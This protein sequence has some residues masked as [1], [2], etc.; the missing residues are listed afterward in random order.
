MSPHLLR[1]QQQQ[2]QQQQQQ[3]KM[4]LTELNSDVTT[5]DV[6]SSPEVVLRFVQ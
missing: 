2:Q 3:R 5:D 4:P 6:G 1:T